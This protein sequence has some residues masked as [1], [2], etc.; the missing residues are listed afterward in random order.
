MGLWQQP[1][2]A[3]WVSGCEQHLTFLGP[4]SWCL[5]THEVQG[6]NA[7]S[8]AVSPI[9]ST[10]EWSVDSDSPKQRAD[11][12]DG[13]LSREQRDGGQDTKL[14]KNKNKNRRLTTCFWTNVW[15]H[16]L[17]HPRSGFFYLFLSSSPTSKDSKSKFPCS[18]TLSSLSVSIINNW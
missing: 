7:K 10:Q 14:L 5:I 11:W 2:W 1:S 18:F 3:I 16:S 8:K 17:L 12:R 13:H 4:L 6:C 9:G 15:N